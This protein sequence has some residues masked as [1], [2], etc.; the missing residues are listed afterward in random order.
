[1][2]VSWVLGRC[3]A[4][5][6]GLV[7][8]YVLCVSEDPCHQGLVPDLPAAQDSAHCQHRGLSSI[9]L[10]GLANTL[11]LQSVQNSKQHRLQGFHVMS[12]SCLPAK[13]PPHLQEYKEHERSREAIELAFDAILQQKMKTRHK[14]G[15]R[16]PRSGRKTDVAGNAVGCASLVAH[17]GYQAAVPSW[18]GVWS[19]AADCW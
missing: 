2:L 9:A 14:Y 5:C 16:P 4:C 18:S 17:N 6:A 1:M 8:W 15:F 3:R 12:S 13:I 10:S 11:P 7:A 19:I